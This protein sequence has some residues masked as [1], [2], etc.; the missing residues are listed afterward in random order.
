LANGTIA[1]GVAFEEWT[2]VHFQGTEIHR[3]V[4][5]R[6]GAKAYSVKVLNGSVEEVLLPVE[7][8]PQ[9]QPEK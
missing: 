9:Y 7:Y 4:A 2:G 1:P 8:L 5:S 6:S 3:V